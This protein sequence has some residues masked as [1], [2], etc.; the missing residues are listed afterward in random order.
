MVRSPIS[1]R[2]VFGGI[3][4]TRGWI[5]CSKVTVNYAASDDISNFWDKLNV[6]NSQS[7]YLPFV[8]VLGSGFI[9]LVTLTF[10]FVYLRSKMLQFYRKLFSFGVTKNSPG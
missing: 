4:S 2:G 7:S 1:P 10:Y 5:I 3:Y 9:V 6:E 8:L